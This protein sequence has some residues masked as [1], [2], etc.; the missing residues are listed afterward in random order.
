MNVGLVWLLIA[1]TQIFMHNYGWFHWKIL[2]QAKDG[3]GPTLLQEKIINYSVGTDFVILEPVSRL[4]VLMTQSSDE[5]TF[6]VH[7]LLFLK[8]HK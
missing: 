8:I 4:C 2:F 3:T 7:H 1:W 5:R 6:F